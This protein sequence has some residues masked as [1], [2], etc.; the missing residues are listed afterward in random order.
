MT[1]KSTPILGALSLLLV[2]SCG[3]GE[4][5]DP[6]AGSEILANGMTVKAQIEARQDGYK[7]IGRNFKAINDELKTSA[8]DVTVI[9]TAL[10]AMLDASSGMADWYPEG[11]GPESGVKTEALDTIWEDPAD[12]A[13]K[14]SDYEAALTDLSAAVE[15][16]DLEAIAAAAQATGPTCGACHDKFRLD[17]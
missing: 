13:T 14:I 15:T 4:P 5:A 1:K 7:A 8:P 6:N 2:A 17:D 16:G 11:T 3:G 9:E 12:F 10:T